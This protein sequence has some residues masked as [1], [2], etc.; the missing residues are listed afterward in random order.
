MNIERLIEALDEYIARASMPK[1]DPERAASRGFLVKEIERLL[2]L[3]NRSLLSTLEDRFTQRVSGIRKNPLNK[4]LDS[5]RPRMKIAWSAVAHQQIT[6]T[7]Y[8]A[9][10]LNEEERNYAEDLVTRVEMLSHAFDRLCELGVEH[11]E[12]HEEMK[13]NQPSPSGINR[14]IVSP[15]VLEREERWRKEV[16]VVTSF[17]CYEIKSLA[18]MLKQWGLQV[19]SPELLYITKTR[20]RFL[21]H[22]RSGGVTRMARRSMTIPYNGGPVEVSIAGLNHWGPITRDHYLSLLNL[23]PPINDSKERLANEQI[24]LS[25]KQ[26][27]QL[28]SAEIVRL[29]AFG[30]RDP[31]LP[32]AL[33]ELADLLQKDALPKIEAAFDDAVKVFGFERFS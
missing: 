26:N 10:T 2:Q 19:N 7:Q 1:D 33:E 24:L 17:A 6:P 12:I 25:K 13:R 8:E 18:D 3:L 16:D 21:A 32:E 14:A 30:L 22:P 11:F 28:P 31:N 4:F 29:K 23:A 27:E 15:S 5:V 9:L 20:D